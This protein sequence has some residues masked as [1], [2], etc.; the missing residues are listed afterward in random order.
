MIFQ[1]VLGIIIFPKNDA[2]L[3][4]RLFSWPINS[5]V[6]SVLIMTYLVHAY[7]YAFHTQEKRP[8]QAIVPLASS[9][10]H[11]ELNVHK[12]A[13]SRI[14]LMALVKE[15]SSNH[16]I[17]PVVSHAG[18]KADYKGQHLIRMNK[19]LSALCSLCIFL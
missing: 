18:F 3:Q 10:H 1:L 7:C 11:V 16:A 6:F 14:A 8:T 2:D 9:A 13:N 12:D 19:I 5:P 17:I 4:H 15:I